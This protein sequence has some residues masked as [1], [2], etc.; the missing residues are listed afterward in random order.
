[1]KPNEVVIFGKKYS[2]TYCSNPSDVDIF[3]RESMFGQ[4]D[5]WTSSIR[6]YDNGRSE[7]DIM[8]TLMHE[9]LH[10]IGWDLKLDILDKGSGRDQDK[11]DELDVLALAL[12]EILVGNGWVKLGFEPPPYVHDGSKA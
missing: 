10:C 7:Q 11:H 2:I 8:Q 12:V 5:F 1:M 3:K 4:T 6:I 9:I